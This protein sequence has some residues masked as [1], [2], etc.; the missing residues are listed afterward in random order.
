[1]LCSIP[2]Y[3]KGVLAKILLEC[4]SLFTLENKISSI[5]VDN[6][7]TNDAMMNV[8]MDKLESSSLMLSGDFLH[9]RCSAHILNLIVRDGLDVFDSAI[10]K[11]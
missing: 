4:F 5:V 10:C 11:V 9:M 8:L 6:A 3:N 1:M 2:I 7:T